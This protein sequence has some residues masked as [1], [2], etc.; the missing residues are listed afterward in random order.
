[1]P[2]IRIYGRWSKN[3]HYYAGYVSKL[4]SRVHLKFDDNDETSHDVS[5]LTAVVLDTTPSEKD[6]K[7]GTKVIAPDPNPK[8]YYYTV[9]KIIKKETKDNGVVYCVRYDDGKESSHTIDKIRVL[10]LFKTEGKVRVID[11]NSTSLITS[12]SY[13]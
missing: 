6:L 2:G 1:M 12:I 10:T 5:D 9:A 7:V 8:C 4:D 11:G 13:E 3:N